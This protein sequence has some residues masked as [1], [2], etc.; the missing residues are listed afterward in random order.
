MT[1]TNSR[2]Y[3]IPKTKFES[4][5]LDTGKE[6]PPQKE[7]VKEEFSAKYI[8]SLRSNKPLHRNAGQ[9]EIDNIQNHHSNAG[10]QRI[11]AD[12]QDKKDPI[13]TTSNQSQQEI[14][15]EIKKLEK[16]MGITARY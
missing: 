7:E 2:G 9:Y 5:V 15:E 4:T 10:R 6:V 12:K 13:H 1:K 14:L 16:S 11:F 8:E 3:S